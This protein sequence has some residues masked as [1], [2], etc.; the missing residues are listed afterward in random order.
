M[1]TGNINIVMTLFAVLVFI[2]MSIVG[3]EVL[4]NYRKS[5]TTVLEADK[6][7]EYMLL[8]DDKNIELYDYK[9]DEGLGI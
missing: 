6:E 9:S 2:S 7:Y 1:N 8:D 4:K 3:Y 5:A